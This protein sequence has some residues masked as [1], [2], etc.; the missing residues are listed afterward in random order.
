[1]LTKVKNDY[2]FNEYTINNA[3]LLFDRYACINS[4]GVTDSVVPLFATVCLQI[5]IKIHESASFKHE[6]IISI[7]YD[8]GWQE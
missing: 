6:Q 7:C 3:I 8:M 2:N 1:M 5:S 4:A